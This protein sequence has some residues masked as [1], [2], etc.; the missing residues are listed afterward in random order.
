M[1]LKSN[2]IALLCWLALILISGS[3]V[4]NITSYIVSRDSL[5]ESIVDRELPITSDSLYSEIQKDL[6]RPI[7]I[8]SQMA[9]NTLLRDWILDGEKD[10]GSLKRYLSEIKIKEK[11]ISS[12]YISEKTRKYY[13]PN[14]VLKMISASDPSDQWYFRAKKISEPYEINI[15]ADAANK[16]TI[17]VFV[18]YRMIDGKGTFLGIVGVGLSL[19]S[20]DLLVE[21]YE[22]Q[23]KRKV[24]FINKD[25]FSTLNGEISNKDNIS[26]KEKAGIKD[27]AEEILTM[28]SN[29]VRS[30][31][32]LGD[33]NIQVNSRYVKELKAYLVVEQSERDALTPLNRVLSINLGLS[34]LLTL[35][36][37]AITL[38]TVNR[39]QQQLEKLAST[40][41]LTGL[42]NRFTIEVQLEKSIESFKRIHQ[43]FTII[44]LDIDVFKK[45]NDSYGHLVGDKAIKIVSNVASQQIRNTDRIS[46][47]GGEEFLVLLNNCNLRDGVLIAEKIRTAI[48]SEPLRLDSHQEIFMTVSLGVGQIQPKE[49]ATSFLGRVDQALYAAKNNGR[50]RT[51]SAVS[52]F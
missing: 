41:G 49:D 14:G 47:W 1:F 8:S 13:Y 30:V 51:E 29:P 5:R 37:L 48:A 20:V 11:A 35:L 18:N 44:L 50:N 25:G 27:I 33:T 26:I 6:V 24:Y 17:T 32:H 42:E 39:Y 3:F 4:T 15:D 16:N 12:F 10:L 9:Q 22:A 52:N 2:R 34:T 46:R 23:Y 36:V 21:H 40:D 45:I 28:S 19:K 7:F 38:A 43:P 31:Y